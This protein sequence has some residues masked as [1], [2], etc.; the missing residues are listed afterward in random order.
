MKVLATALLAL[1]LAGC[2]AY[3]GRGL[4]PGTS[5]L[6]DVQRVMGEPAMRWRD[7]DG[8]ETLVYPRGPAGYHTFMIRV[9]R[10]GVLASRENVLEPRHFARIREG[11]SEDDVLRTLGPPYPGWT[12]FYAGTNQLVWEWRWCDDWGEPARFNVF[13][14]GSSKRV[15]TTASLTERQAMPFGRGDRRDWCSR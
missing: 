11:M 4:E 7:A 1:V 2:A 13:F 12:Q 3:D 9:D 5:R 15:R 6:A 10:N 14:D 8:G